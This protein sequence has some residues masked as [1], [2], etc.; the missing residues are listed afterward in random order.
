M[1]SYL[2]ILVIGGWELQESD[3][4][5]VRGWGG[6]CDHSAGGRAQVELRGMQRSCSQECLAPGAGCWGSLVSSASLCSHLLSKGYD[7]LT[8]FCL[9]PLVFSRSVGDGLQG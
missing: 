2:I 3:E 5:H 8:L 7:S 6:W 9:P 4:V 1:Q